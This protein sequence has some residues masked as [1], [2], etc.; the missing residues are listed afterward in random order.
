M[1]EGLKT[2]FGLLE[3]RL[4][5]AVTASSPSLY[6]QETTQSPIRFWGFLPLQVP[7]PNFLAQEA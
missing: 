3:N 1:I 2:W 5:S 4:S 6:N 7:L